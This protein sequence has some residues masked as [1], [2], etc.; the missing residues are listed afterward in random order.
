[1]DLEL[2]FSNAVPAKVFPGPVVL[3]IH[4]LKEVLF[5]LFLWK[6]TLSHLPRSFLLARSIP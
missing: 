2:A 4:N 1:M 3:P 5:E 6:R